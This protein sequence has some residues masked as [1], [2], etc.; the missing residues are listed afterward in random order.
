MSM[1]NK[2]YEEVSNQQLISGVKSTSIL[3]S[4][5]FPVTKP[6]VST[7]TVQNPSVIQICPFIDEPL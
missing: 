1:K 7:P 2:M 4:S 6:I 5:Y 3:K